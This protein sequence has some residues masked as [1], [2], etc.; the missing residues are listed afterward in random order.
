MRAQLMVLALGGLL[1]AA[2]AQGQDPERRPMPGHPETHRMGMMQG[3]M[4][5]MHG[6]MGGPMM[7][8][9][10]REALQLTPEQV[11]RIE[12]I[13]ARAHPEAHPRMQRAMELH[14]QAM[15]ALMGATPDPARHDALLRQAMEQMLQA[16]SAMARAMVEAQEVLT[17]G[18]RDNLRFAAR[19][20]EAMRGGME[21]G[22]MHGPGA[23]HR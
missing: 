23:Q 11:R 7:I 12:A 5:G 10:L 14:R 4:A 16:H 18:Q 20:M 17:P 2:P 1:A 13:H 21:R 6:M 22:M 19:A 9:H 8:L 3:G 15:G